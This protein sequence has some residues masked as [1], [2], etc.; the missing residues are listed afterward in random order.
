[1]KITVFDVQ[2]ILAKRD[3][4]AIMQQRRDQLASMVQNYG[5]EVT[6]AATGL[7]ATTIQ[8]YLRD[9]WARISGDCIAQALYVFEQLKYK[10]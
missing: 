1:M 7:K 9:Q 6:S 3:E 4:A 10:N 2:Q 8:V 5:L